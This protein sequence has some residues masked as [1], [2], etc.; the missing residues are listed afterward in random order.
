MPC[1]VVAFTVLGGALVVC[2]ALQNKCLVHFVEGLRCAK[3]CP[4]LDLFVNSALFIPTP[5]PSSPRLHPACPGKDFRTWQR[6][7]RHTD[8]NSWANLRIHLSYTRRLA[9]LAVRCRQPGRG[10]LRLRQHHVA[11]RGRAHARRRHHETPF[12]LPYY[13]SSSPLQR[14]VCLSVGWLTNRRY[15]GPALAL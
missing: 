8:Q 13:Y 10:V 12:M 9:P 11:R 1:I 7:L 14:M 5:S 2:G 3:L 15:W 6:R 4:W